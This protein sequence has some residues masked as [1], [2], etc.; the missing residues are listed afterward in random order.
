MFF[1]SRCW[2]HQGV[3]FSEVLHPGAGGALPVEVSLTQLIHIQGMQV[4]SV[5]RIVNLWHTHSVVVP[6]QVPT[7][8]ATICS[9]MNWHNAPEGVGG[10]GEGLEVGQSGHDRQA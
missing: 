6:V 8:V 9:G 3:T 4:W 5:H 2:T 10:G 1:K 7:P